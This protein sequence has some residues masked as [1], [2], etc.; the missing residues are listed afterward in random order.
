MTRIFLALLLIVPLGISAQSLEVLPEQQFNTATSLQV[1]NTLEQTPNLLSIDP[2]QVR[3]LPDE[4]TVQ[5]IRNTDTFSVINAFPYVLFNVIERGLPAQTVILILMIPVLTTLLVFTRNIVGIPS[6]DM[7]VIIALSIA[8]LAS[9]LLIGLILLATI[10]LS[11]AVARILFKRIKIMQMPKISLSMMVVSFSVL[12]V[13]SVLAFSNVMP[14]DSI[15]IVPILLLIILSER[16]VRLEFERK[17]RQVWTLV[18]ASLA[19]G[20]FGYFLL[21]SEFV[22]TIVLN[23]PELIIALIP[24]N[25]YMGRYFGLRFAEYYRFSEIM[26]SKPAK[27]TNA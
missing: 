13:L 6:L 17:P 18:I 9:D 15:S 7:L 27:K 8:L 26:E 2:Q 1:Q 11:S 4:F 14:V 12:L 16:I 22:R 5:S 10:L 24:L 3:T 25:L 21:L 19:L 20:I 23:F